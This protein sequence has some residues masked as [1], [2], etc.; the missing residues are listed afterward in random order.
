MIY[1]YRQDSGD[2]KRKIQFTS[3]GCPVSSA[4]VDSVQT[5]DS[6]QQ[7]TNKRWTANMIA[8]CQSAASMVWSSV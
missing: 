7:T 4:T 5:L 8:S 1:D 3:R 2:S 6:D